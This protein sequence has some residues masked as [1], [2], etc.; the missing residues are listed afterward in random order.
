M[1]VSLADNALTTLATLKED[2][3]ISGSSDD[4]QLNRIINAASDRVETYCQRS[5]YRVTTET[6]RVPGYGWTK[7]YLART[8]VNSITSVTYDGDTV[9]SDNYNLRDADS[10]LVEKAGGWVWSAHNANDITKGPMPGSERY[11]YLFTYDGGWYTPKQYD[12][13]NSNT[14]A[15]PWDIEDACLEICRALWYAKKRGDPSIVSEKL[16]DWSASYGSSAATVDA[17]S[18]LPVAAVVTLK[19]YRRIVMPGV[20]GR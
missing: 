10:G 3:G 20:L 13:D 18:G 12:D 14:R 7:M 11:L 16:M 5:F 1:T 9:D 17:E 6:D 2:L 15:L 19:R 4:D 8:P